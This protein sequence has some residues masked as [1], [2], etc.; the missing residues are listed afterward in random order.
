MLKNY[1]HS[2]KVG[3]TVILLSIFYFSL[4]SGYSYCQLSNSAWPMYQHD[5]MHKG[6]GIN[7][8]KTTL[9]DLKWSY[10]PNDG[11]TDFNS[12]PVIDIDGSLYISCTNGVLYKVNEDG[13]LLWTYD[14]GDD[15]TSNSPAISSSG[16]LYFGSANSFYCLASDGSLIWSNDSLQN[17]TSPLI[18]SAGN[19]ITTFDG[20]GY[21]TTYSLDP[22]NG[23]ILDSIMDN[24]SPSMNNGFPPAMNGN[25]DFF[26][27]FYGDATNSL[28]YNIQDDFS[29][30]TY[31]NTGTGINTPITIGSDGTLYFGTNADGLF[32]WN[33]DLSAALWSIPLTT[34]INGSISCYY[35]SGE[36]IDLLYFGTDS[37]HLVC[38]DSGG[39]FRWSYLT[40]NTIQAAPAIDTDGNAVVNSNDNFVHV[41]SKT[42]VLRWYYD[43]GNAFG[44]SGPAIGDDG[45]IYVASGSNLIAFDNPPPPT[46]TSTLTPSATITATPTLPP[47]GDGPWPMFRQDLMHKGASIEALPQ[48]PMTMWT[49][50]TNG[51]FNSSPAQGLGGT[52]YVGNTNGSL[53][54]FNPDGSLKWTY[55]TSGPI[56]SSPFVNVNEEIFF[57]SEDYKL[58]SLDATGNLIWTYETDGPITSSPIIETDLWTTYIGSLDNYLY[59]INYDGS[60]RWKYPTESWVHS[61]PALAED[62]TIY[63]GSYD[64]NLYALDPDG[65]LQWSYT[66]GDFISSSPL[67]DNMGN[68][69]FGSRDH[70]IYSLKNNGV[71]RWSY[72]TGF[73]VESSPAIWIDNTL[74]IASRDKTL[75]ALKSNDG[76]LKWSYNANNH[77]VSSPAFAKD[78]SIIIGDRDSNLYAFDRYGNL[79]WSVPFSGD[80]YASPI[81]GKDSIV[82]CGD[83]NG[84]FYAIAPKPTPTPTT[85]LTATNTITATPTITLTMSATLSPTPSLTATITPTKTIT[86]TITP[87]LTP[88]LTPLPIKQKLII[89]YWRQTSDIATL[90]TVTNIDPEDNPLIYVLFENRTTGNR[91]EL[92]FDLPS[93]AT[94]AIISSL[95]VPENGRGHVN[96]S[97][98]EGNLNVW[99][100]I[101][102]KKEFKG[103]PVNFEFRIGSPVYFPFWQVSEEIDTLITMSSAKDDVQ[104]TIELFDQSGKQFSTIFRLIESGEVIELSLSEFTTNAIGSGVITYPAGSLNIFGVIENL[105][106][107]TGYPMNFESNQKLEQAIQMVRYSTF[108]QTDL[109]NSIDTW[110]MFNN[111]GADT[112][113]A[114][115][116]LKDSE[117]SNLKEIPVTLNSKNMNFFNV[118]NHVSKGIGTA[119]I[120]WTDGMIVPWSTIINDKGGYPVGFEQLQSSPIYIP[121]WQ[122]N[123]RNGISTYIAL[124]NIDTV[125]ITPSLTVSN[126]S[127]LSLL[128]QDIDTVSPGELVIVDFSK[129]FSID[130]VTGTAKI[131][132]NPLAKLSVWGV[133]FSNKSKTGYPL[134]FDNIYN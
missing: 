98:A 71:F 24:T 121:F 6:L 86:K 32:A 69:Y 25:G 18:T 73:Y 65:N 63:F 60:L 104:A 49:Y 17:C 95:V 97:W 34:T 12:S 8:V 57:G 27:T 111:P 82:Y 81:I 122:V 28:I 51:A 80:I 100:A 41:V 130:N 133:I 14:T 33:P 35:D 120:R 46:P 76:S 118:S 52:I 128:N 67:I 113:E 19:I 44:Q 88:T 26:C 134:T 50:E 22:D 115:V 20:S 62:G 29:S 56:T 5:P 55:K 74:S 15:F 38:C 127:G 94:N 77:F 9:P 47:A 125:D 131:E 84:I 78:G 58:Y 3:F 112:V 4:F 43:N 48:I 11:C 39:N 66:T 103:F 91:N 16:N 72:E 123:S 10:S 75:Y 114:A 101:F 89:P 107:R 79:K 83:N 116:T 119:E 23:S 129:L 40:G 126:A 93:N 37:F 45:T 110:M 54:A 124:N 117:G 106:T 53:Y 108:W 99:E 1:P 90:L 64:N 132:F 7:D 102:Y 13:N 70:K 87:T 36:S 96:L 68:I 2:S 21:S 61:S 85:T 92:R 59:A 30:D 31:V 105:R 109:D 42:G